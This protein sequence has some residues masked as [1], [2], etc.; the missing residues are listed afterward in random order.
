MMQIRC[1]N[2]HGQNRG[3]KKRKLSKKSELNENWG[4]FIILVEIGRGNMQFTSYGGMDGPAW[5]HKPLK[6]D[7]ANLARGVL[8]RIPLLS[9][10]IAPL[11]DLIPDDG[12][13][14]PIS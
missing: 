12:K 11:R 9:Q 3:S 13:R 4:T 8:R 10:D 7:S 14:D 1:I 6:P 2:A 5:T